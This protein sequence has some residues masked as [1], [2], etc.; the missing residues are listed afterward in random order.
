MHKGKITAIGLAILLSLLTLLLLSGVPVFKLSNI[1]FYNLISGDQQYVGSDICGRCHQEQYFAWQ[2]SLHS[3]MYKPKDEAVIHADF[4]NPDEIGFSLDDVDWV[5]GSKWKQ[6]FVQ[7]R[8]GKAYVYPAI[9][10]IEAKKWKLK[11][12]KNEQIAGELC[13]GCHTTGFDFS[14]K[15]FSEDSIGCEA[16]H[17]PGSK[18]VISQKRED[19][20][21]SPQVDIC[22]QCHTR[23]ISQ[24]GKTP[25]PI[26]YKLGEPIENYFVTRKTWD[27]KIP[28]KHRQHHDEFTSSKHYGAFT[29]LHKDERDRN[30]THAGQPLKD[31]C[32]RCHSH[33][34]KQ[35]NGKID[36][37]LVRY[38]LTCVTCHNPHDSLYSKKE[39]V[40]VASICGGCHVNN[41]RKYGPNQESHFPCPENA[42]S[43]PDCH[44]P[45]IKYVAEK[46][47][48]RDHSFKIITP[49]V[50]EQN[51]IPSSCSVESCHGDLATSQIRNLYDSWYG[52]GH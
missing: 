18:H 43:C 46:F 2:G 26:D 42:V 33:E 22:S 37:D 4:S 40:K 9:W 30:I 6:E 27:G 50:A 38:G 35:N 28:I 16:C 21:S 39:S 19:I 31:G 44:M 48:M 23:G 49:D 11:K 20:F 14:T 3:K 52:T 34:G 1:Y 25:F 45:L 47:D 24:D 32:L 5:I 8:D 12:N 36:I 13:D 51:Q 41:L 15:A 17:G 10:K 7:I 29:I